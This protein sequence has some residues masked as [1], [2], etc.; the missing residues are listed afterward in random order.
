MDIL[1]PLF[2]ALSLTRCQK[3][4]EINIQICQKLCSLVPQKTHRSWKATD[5]LSLIHTTLFNAQL[6]LRQY[7]LGLDSQELGKKGWGAITSTIILHQDAQPSPLSLL[8]RNFPGTRWWKEPALH[9]R[10][11]AANE[12][13]VLTCTPKRWNS[14]MWIKSVSY[15]LLWSSHDYFSSDG[16]YMKQLFAIAAL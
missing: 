14:T 9:E 13:H 6:S 10:S 4:T 2:A 8:L 15:E 11:S 12:R 1:L 3:H 16:D 7:W 5:N